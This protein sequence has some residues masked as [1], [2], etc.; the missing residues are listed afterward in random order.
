MGGGKHGGVLFVGVEQS[1]IFT[2]ETQR[3]S[4]PKKGFLCVSVVKALR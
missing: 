3:T 2:T 4:K 1:Q